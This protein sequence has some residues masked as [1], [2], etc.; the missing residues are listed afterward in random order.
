M[1]DRFNP[2]KSPNLR[3]ILTI[4]RR[5]ENRINAWNEE[6]FSALSFGTAKDTE[7]VSIKLSGSTG[8][9]GL[10]K[11]SV[12]TWLLKLGGTS[13]MLRIVVAR[14]VEYL[15][16][17]YPPW[18]RAMIYCRDI[19]LD[20]YPGIRSIGIGDIFRRLCCKMV[21]LI[22]NDEATIVCRINQLCCGFQAGIEGAVHHIRGL[23]EN[24][25]DDEEPW[26]I[27]LINARFFSMKATES[28]W[29][30]LLDVFGP[31]VQNFSLI[32]IVATRF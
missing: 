17:G 25:T 27:L 20:K 24:Y 22:T 10:N 18:A 6:T 12:S 5:I 7:P 8:A 29:Y 15:A 30:G 3:G 4:K 23:R 16:N 26:G 31:P 21:L 2:E 9:S 19:G 14:L 28:R 32:S 11:I 1:A 13:K